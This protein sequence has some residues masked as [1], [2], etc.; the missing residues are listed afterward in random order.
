MNRWTTTIRA[1]VCVLFCASVA[2][3]AMAGDYTQFPGPRLDPRTIDAQQQVEDIY[4]AGDYARALLIY[5]KELAPIGDK[6]A[7]YM[8]GYMHLN[9]QGTPKSLPDALAWFRLAAERKEPAILQ[10][11][12]TLY[13]RMNQEQVVQS[14]GIFVELWRELGDNRLVLDLI[15]EDLDQLRAR[16]GSRIPSSSTSPI[17]IVDIRRGDSTGDSYYDRVRDRIRLRMDYLDSNV[18]IVDLDLGDELAVTKSLEL[19]LREEMA[20]LDMR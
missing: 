6:Y 7:Q 2:P 13:H 12:D 10:A 1:V 5:E 18:E 15:R 4:E 3:V 17:T 8:V 19:E 9:G 11:R 14:N 20:A 16:T